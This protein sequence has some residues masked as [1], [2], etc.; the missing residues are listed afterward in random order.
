MIKRLLAFLAFS[1]IVLVAEAQK[2]EYL[3]SL[4]G[5]IPIGDFSSNDVESGAFAQRGWGVTLEN[6]FSFSKWP[7]WLG[8]GFHFSYQQLEVDE[9]G[10][11]EAFS[12]VLEGDITTRVFA[13]QYHPLIADVCA[14]Y[15]LPVTDKLTI[16]FKGGVGVLFTIFDPIRIDLY[17]DQGENL[18][19]TQLDFETKPYFN[20]I[21]GANLGYQ[22]SNT[23][24]AKIFADYN[25]SNVNI[26]SSYLL[27]EITS[28]QKIS[29]INTGIAISIT[30]N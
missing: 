16:D 13:D 27:Q 4:H 30:I 29:I 24:G 23:L 15:E 2:S 18:L 17:N 21:L 28:D 5:S 10:I 9:Q 12:D 7:D 8:V 1:L 19:R 3:I 25:H 11:G 26:S 20:F 14:F 22:F 6:K